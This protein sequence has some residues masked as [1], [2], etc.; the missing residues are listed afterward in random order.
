MGPDQIEW[1]GDKTCCHASK[2][3]TKSFPQFRVG[4]LA[5]NQVFID[6]VEVELA[7]RERHDF[8][9]VA[10]ITFEKAV[11]AFSLPHVDEGLAEAHASVLGGL[12][13]FQHFQAFKWVRHRAGNSPCYGS[14]EEETV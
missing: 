8:D 12:D 4:L 3:T 10:P 5:H 13:L 9:A 14:C 7:G 2:P 11:E 1:M 6:V